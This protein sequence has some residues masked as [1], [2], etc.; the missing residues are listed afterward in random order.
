MAQT[1][2][3]DPIT[4]LNGKICRHK[5]T[6]YKVFRASGKRF[7]TQIC[8][9][10]NLSTNPYTQDELERQTK[11]ATARTNMDAAMADPVKKAQ[12]EAAFK[13]QKNG[14]K[15]KYATLY[16]YVFAMEYAKLSE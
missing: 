1:L 12:Y 8:N 11:F 14:K 7:T 2:F 9:P 4:S 13:Q 6:I 10:R 16:G 15:P 3:E 5:K